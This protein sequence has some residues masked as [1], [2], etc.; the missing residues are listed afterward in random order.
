MHPSTVGYLQHNLSH[1]RI[2]FIAELERLAN[3]YL[4]RRT[5]Q[6][7]C[8]RP[9]AAALSHLLGIL[10]SSASSSASSSGSL[11]ALALKLP[12]PQGDPLDLPRALYTQQTDLTRASVM[13]LDYPLQVLVS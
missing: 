7:L 12:L 13:A 9:L 5:H 4:C 3:S 2:S 11:S 1:C 8:E 10:A 6:S